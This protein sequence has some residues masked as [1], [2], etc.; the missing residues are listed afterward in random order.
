MNEEGKKATSTT[1]ELSS[2]PRPPSP[3]P[4]LHV[5]IQGRALFLPGP[6]CSP[7]EDTLALAPHA[8]TQTHTHPFFSLGYTHTLPTPHHPPPPSIARPDPLAPRQLR[9]Q[10]VEGVG[11]GREGDVGPLVQ[12]G[13]QEGGPAKQAQAGAQPA[14]GLVLWNEE[15]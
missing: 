14:E 15:R 9:L 8:R 13:G 1:K 12:A 6:I 4:P 11:P 5:Q 7:R 10:P 2:T 3:P